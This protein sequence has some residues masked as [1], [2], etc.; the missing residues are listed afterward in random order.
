[1]RMLRDMKLRNKF[2]LALLLPIA[3][4]LYFAAVEVASQYRVSSD[5]DRVVSLVDFAVHTSDVV[6]ELQK[7]RGLTGGFLGSE[8]AEFSNELAVQRAATDEQISGLNSFLD[9]FRQLQDEEITSEDLETI[10]Q[11]LSA[12]AGH[13]RAVN[14]QTVDAVEGIGFYTQAN[15][16]LLESANLLTRASSNSRIARMA[17]AHVSFLQAKERAG[18]ERAV[19]SSI[20]SGGQFEG[21]GYDRWIKLVGAQETYLAVFRAFA[22]SDQLQVFEAA[23]TGPEMTEVLRLRSQVK[24]NRREGDKLP[25]AGI[26]FDAATR[27]IDEL[28]SI[29]D[30]LSEDL[31]A[32]A[33]KLDGDANRG[34]L[35]AVLLSVMA[36]GAALIVSW[37]VVRGVTKPVLDAR[38]RMIDIA[39]GEGDLTQRIVNES[40]DE[41]GQLCGAINCFIVKIHDV[42][43]N[44]KSSVD[45]VGSA[46]KHVASAALD[47]ASG[48][49]Q[50]A[51]GA[52]QTS[53]TLGQMNDAVKQN[54][55]SAKQTESMAADASSQAEAGGSKVK[56]TVEAMKDIASKIGIIEEI[57]QQTNLLALNATIEAARAGEHGRGFAVVAS[58]VGK[59]ATRSKG[60]AGEI[61]ELARKSVEVAED[62]GNSLEAIVATSRKTTDLVQE[63]AAASVEHSTGIEEINTTVNQLAQV[64]ENNAALS[65]EL[66]ATSEQMSAQAASLGEMISFFKVAH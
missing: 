66:S 64:T 55:Q 42:I 56:E 27:R 48:S 65:E 4:L 11:N 63:I 18:I 46:S 35:F 32:T 31:S 47:L 17:A 59:L 20:L 34:L 13:R 29:E 23:S 30:Q 54:A 36:T 39:A 52:E 25:D 21:D 10:N 40:T 50:Q 51:A 28:K 19:L 3:G 24:K 43:G 37:L 60:A 6:H 22:T 44:M 2:L 33:V 57:S 1:M 38:D 53:A 16:Q 12:L 45:E 7:E 8:G 14:Q 58:E 26:W 49:S 41:L 9:S 61:S 15:T 62:A 5:M